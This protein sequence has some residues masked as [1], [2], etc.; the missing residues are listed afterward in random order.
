MKKIFFFISAAA[1]LSSCAPKIP[2]TQAI[3]E[4]YK[5]TDDEIKQLQFYVSGDIVLQSVDEIAKG[6]TTQD[7]E[8]VIVDGKTVEQVFIKQYTPGVAEKIIDDKKIGVSFE[9]GKYL[10]FG[11]A[12]DNK[13]PYRLLAAEWVNRRGKVKYGDK[14]YYTTPGSSNVYLL[15]KMKK[16][17]KLRKKQHVV[18]GR[19][20]K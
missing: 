17:N 4:Q 7:G 2:F 10:V 1:L 18:K 19:K 16:L 13:G 5:L 14:Y 20:V 9:P 11:D 8:L 3:R 12:T 15:F 6:K